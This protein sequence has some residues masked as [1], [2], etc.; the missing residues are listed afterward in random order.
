MEGHA[1]GHGQLHSHPISPSPLPGH[2]VP[3][4]HPHSPLGSHQH[5]QHH[6]NH[7]HQQQQLPGY[8]SQGAG[9]PTRSTPSG[10]GENYFHDGPLTGGSAPALPPFLGSGFLP[11]AS[12]GSYDLNGGGGQCGA[13]P[14]SS[15]QAQTAEQQALQQQGGGSDIGYAFS[16]SSTV[17]AVG[18]SEAGA[19]AGASGGRGGSRDAGGTRTAPAGASRGRAAAGGGQ[20]GAARRGGGGGG[21][22]PSIQQQQQQQQHARLESGSRGSAGLLNRSASDSALRM[23]NASGGA[24]AA[25]SLTGSGAAAVSGSATGP[26]SSVD[27]AWADG[28]ASGSHINLLDPAGSAPLNSS[29]G[30]GLLPAIGSRSAGRALGI[31]AAGAEMVVVEEEES[32][33]FASPVQ[34]PA[35]VRSSLSQSQVQGLGAAGALTG[36]GA[37]TGSGAAAS[38]SGASR[39][40]APQTGGGAVAGP[41]AAPS[42]AAG[43]GA[44]ADLRR[45]VAELNGQVRCSD[46]ATRMQMSMLRIGMASSVV[47]AAVAMLC[48]VLATCMLRHGRFA[49]RVAVVV[50]VG[51]CRYHGSPCSCATMRRRRLHSCRR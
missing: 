36:T 42:G 13:E 2:Q 34:Q 6:H 51:G 15:Q 8:P 38:P 17:E 23:A 9:T 41:G 22:Q 20:G 25:S 39:G 35:N 40:A 10:S 11:P 37:G 49:H 1:Q 50:L 47:S 16:S 29:L 7:H 12:G 28:G 30:P 18:S 33:E 44:S 48:L 43:A 46:G 21:P 14:Y 5:H 31:A 3:G 32:S 27:A 24:A 45:M 19:W 26:V 4:Q